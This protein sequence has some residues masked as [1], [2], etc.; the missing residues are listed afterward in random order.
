MIEQ[1]GGNILHTSW[2]LERTESSS[3]ILH[4][5]MEVPSAL[6]ILCKGS[7]ATPFCT[8]AHSNNPPDRAR[9]MEIAATY[10]SLPQKLH[11]LKQGPM[12]RCDAKRL[13]KRLF[14]H[15][16]KLKLTLSVIDARIL[17]SSSLN[18]FSNLSPPNLSSAS[19]ESISSVKCVVRT[20]PKLSMIS[21]NVLPS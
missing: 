6:H 5:R 15:E 2:S 20:G 3:L 10:A 1:I 7:I 18:T 8:S 17:A 12:V 14:L 19:N 21:L 11:R 4:L 16:K 9:R 13:L